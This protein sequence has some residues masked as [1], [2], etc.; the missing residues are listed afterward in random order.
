MTVE[1]GAIDNL[2]ARAEQACRYVLKH[3]EDSWDGESKDSEYASGFAVACKVCEKAIRE[4]I[5]SHLAEDLGHRMLNELA[6]IRQG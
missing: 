6:G 4:H 1:A 2:I 3:N 5:V